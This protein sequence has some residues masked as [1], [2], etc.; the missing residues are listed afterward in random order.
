MNLEKAKELIK[1]YSYKNYKDMTRRPNGG[2]KYPFIVPGSQSYHGC[3]WDWDSW[4]T[5]IAI[6]QMLKDKGEED[7]FL[8]YERGCLL[9]FLEHQDEKGGIPIVLLADGDIPKGEGLYKSNMHK[10]CLVQHL[11]FLIKEDGGK[12]AWIEPYFSNLEKFMAVYLNEY[13][14][15][16]GLYFWLDDSRIG[17]DNDPCTFYR[18]D[19]S[20]GSI[21]LNALMY[22]ELLAM[23]YVCNL[24]GK[25]DRAAFYKEEAETLKNAVREHCFDERDGFFY[26]VDFNL[27]PI[28]ND[29][30]LHSGAP[31]HWDCLIQRIDVWS[32]VLALWAEIATPEQAKA[33]LK[34]ITEERTFWAPYGIRTLSKMEKMY[35]IK[36]TGNPSCWLGPIWGISNYMTFSA[37]AKYGFS[38]EAAE[39][40]EKT[41]MLFGEDIEKCG[42]L[43]EYYD[44]ETGVGVNNPGFQNWNLLA[45]NMIAYLDKK[46]RVIEF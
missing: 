24:L 26:S 14:H 13:K 1:E 8:E 27:N 6:R 42:E 10:P 38:K 2:I 31:R 5:N 30:G 4:L 34:H 44:P 12:T 21:Y 41:I 9:N 15:Q 23:E 17:V 22:K 40:A 20:S 46:E 39:I 11:A 32:G 36:K 37:L 35:V 3:L 28:K 33:T 7:T 16:T 29:G 45:L 18:P 25:A 43:H 19:K